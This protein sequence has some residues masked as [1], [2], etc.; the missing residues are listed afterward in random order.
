MVVD[1]QGLDADAMQRIA[2]WTNLSE[3]AFLLP[4]TQPQADYR[5]RIFTPR[6]ELP[7][8]GHPSVGS[9]YVAIETGF[10]DAG[11]DRLVQQCEAGLLPCK[12]WARVRGGS[13]MCKHHRPRLVDWTTPCVNAWSAR[14]TS[15]CPMDKP[16]SSTT[17]RSGSCAISM[18]PPRYAV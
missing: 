17:A 9:A 11:K 14:C 4:P 8:A 15:H 2:R 7:F 18:A 5:V 13:S 16:A 1:A 12:F 3:T 6:Q 10:V